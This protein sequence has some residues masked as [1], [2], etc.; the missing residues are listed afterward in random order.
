MIWTIYKKFQLSFAQNTNR[1][2]Y[3]L[4]KIKFLGNYI[5]E[6]WYVWGG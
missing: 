1:F 3:S 6:E 2:I 4:K 5:S